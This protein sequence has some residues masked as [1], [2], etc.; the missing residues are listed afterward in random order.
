MKT[1]PMTRFL[2]IVIFLI[3]GLGSLDAR[4][5][6]TV[7]TEWQQGF[8]LPIIPP[9][10]D[11]PAEE[12]SRN[13]SCAKLGM[14]R[15]VVWLAN[16]LLT[17]KISGEEIHYSDQEVLFLIRQSFCPIDRVIELPGERDGPILTCISYNYDAS[18]LLVLEYSIGLLGLPRSEDLA[19]CWKTHNS[20][21]LME[22]FD[23]E[24]K[25]LGHVPLGKRPRAF[26]QTVYFP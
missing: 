16:A 23:L 12:Y 4:A 5:D 14:Q 8:G 6:G 22:C 24:R 13:E 18:E 11:S 15:C 25:I 10:E 2:F 1:F 20:D 3:L 17:K 19:E 26:S 21:N 7:Q 9:D